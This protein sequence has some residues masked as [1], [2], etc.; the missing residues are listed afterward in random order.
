M[1]N[2]ILGGH[3]VALVGQAKDFHQHHIWCILL[4]CTRE[5]IS[6]NAAPI[7]CNDQLW[8][9]HMQH[10]WHPTETSDLVVYDLHTVYMLPHLIGY[11]NWLNGW[12]KLYCNQ[13]SFANL[14]DI[15]NNV[16]VRYLWNIHACAPIF[17]NWMDHFECDGLHNQKWFRSCE[18]FDSLSENR[19]IS[20][21][22][23]AICN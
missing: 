19:L 18:G 10:S 7:P 3:P 16:N 2:K 11:S 15:T 6:L 9:P 5:K 22:Q 21:D 1:K 14:A 12:F 8:C 23:Q 17:D 4:P 13:S 20:F